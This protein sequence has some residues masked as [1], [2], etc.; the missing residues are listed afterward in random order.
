M[1]NF[2]FEN[3]LRLAFLHTTYNR[4]G[5]C[6]FRCPDDI[7]PIALNFQSQSD[8][9]EDPNNSIKMNKQELD[10][11]FKYEDVIKDAND[12]VTMKLNAAETIK[13]ISSMK[14]FIISKG[15]MVGNIS[16]ESDYTR[17]PTSTTIIKKQPQPN[18]GS[19]I[20][21][22]YNNHYRNEPKKKK[23]GSLHL[24]PIR[25]MHENS[26]ANRNSISENINMSQQKKYSVPIKT[27]G[28]LIRNAKY[29]YSPEKKLNISCKIDRKLAMIGVKYTQ[30]P[31]L[32]KLKNTLDQVGPMK[33]I[34]RVYPNEKKLKTIE[35][36]QF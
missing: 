15:E 34:T 33:I 7:T 5:H 12:K 19:K 26:F 18:K 21:V 14:P 29:E 24:R 17:S 27:H 10:E 16:I 23:T 11:C 13:K 20:T 4:D 6:Y 3:I 8:N 1:I 22:V 35:Q 36:K 2:R 25:E 28:L 30:P 9:K 31:K 32:R